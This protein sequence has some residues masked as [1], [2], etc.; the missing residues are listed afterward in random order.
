M[1]SNTLGYVKFKASGNIYP[2]VDK[3]E[4]GYC[5]FDPVSLK[6][7][8]VVSSKYLE[9]VT[10]QDEKSPVETVPH[11]KNPY[12][13]KGKEHLKH[14]VVDGVGKGVE[15]I[16]N[17]LGGKQSKVSYR[18]DLLDAKSMFEMTKV[19]H[20][21]AIKYGEDNWRLISVQ[22]HLNHLIIHAYAYLAGDK[23]DE[24]LSHILCRA[25]FAQGVELQKG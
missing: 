7:E 22:E 12:A 2:Y 14:M 23:S 20:E 1:E 6:K 19:L 13:Y 21:G 16:T 9:E 4:T 11:V 8:W 10:E 17:E 24:H 15:T 25:M 18:F 5:I 3:D